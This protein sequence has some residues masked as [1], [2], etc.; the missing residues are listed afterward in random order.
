[1]TISRSKPAPATA[2]FQQPL[3][4]SIEEK[5]SGHWP[6]TDP[7][8]NAWT[9]RIAKLSAKA[10]QDELGLSPSDAVDL[11]RTLFERRFPE[12]WR[13]FEGI[14]QSPG[15]GKTMDVKLFDELLRYYVIF[16]FGN[17]AKAARELGMKDN[18]LREFIYSRE[19]R[20]I[21]SS[22]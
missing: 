21:P 14:V 6:P 15:S 16:A 11:C 12:L 4:R 19:Q 17:P 22:E 7:D 20:R 18:A 10:I 9:A 5:N 1:M 13:E 8:P 3:E 2:P